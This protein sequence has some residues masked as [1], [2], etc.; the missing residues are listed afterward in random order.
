[1]LRA[2]A[3]VCTSTWF[4]DASRAVPVTTS[5]LRCLASWLS[6]PDRRFTTASLCA[7]SLAKSNSGA[8]NVTP[9][10]ASAAASPIVNA[11]CKSAL[12]G[13]QPTFRHTPPSAA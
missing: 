2:P 6:P 8:P 9:C 10:S 5:T 7:R 13:M 11:T 1:M 12:D 3:A 4:G